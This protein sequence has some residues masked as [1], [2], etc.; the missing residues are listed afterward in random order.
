[1]HF[2]MEQSAPIFVV[3]Q[4]KVMCG[5]LER[6]LRAAGKVESAGSGRAALMRMSMTDFRCIVLASPILVE[7][8]D[9]TFTLIELLQQMAPNLAN[10]VIV[11]TAASATEVID[12]ALDL[13]VY[14][15]FVRPFEIAELRDAVTRCLRH[16]P[17][18]RRVYR[19]SESPAPSA[20]P[21]RTP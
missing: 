18:S 8:G 12:T 2:S 13:N 1:M 16:D 11:L 20:A 5:V 15:I 14:A 7:F 4:D 3:E 6:A 19:R 17:P 21:L 9:E 10:R